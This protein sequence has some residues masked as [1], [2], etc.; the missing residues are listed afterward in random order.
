MSVQEEPLDNLLDNL[1][2]LYDK[3]CPPWTTPALVLATAVA[4]RDTAREP[5]LR[6]TAQALRERT[7]DQQRQYEDALTVTQGAC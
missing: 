3:T 4:L 6:S 5:L 7:G 1:D 2:H